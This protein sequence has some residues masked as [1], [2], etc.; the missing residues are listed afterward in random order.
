M[1]NKNTPL[2]SPAEAAL[3]KQILSPQSMNIILQ[4]IKQH[5]I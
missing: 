4:K 5:K 2:K 1:Q 3:T